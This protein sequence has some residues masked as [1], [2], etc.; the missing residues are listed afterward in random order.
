M[1]YEGSHEGVDR[2]GL[3]VLVW[4]SFLC[5]L[6]VRKP[7]SKNTGA[8]PLI[9][10][11]GCVLV[12]PGDYNVFEDRKTTRRHP[13]ALNLCDMGTFSGPVYKGAVLYWGPKTD[14]ILENCPYD[15]DSLFD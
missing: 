4:W 8:F 9:I 14:P 6:S 7:N 13:E 1:L 15:I 12:R 3:K 10:A 5:F 2:Q 11:T